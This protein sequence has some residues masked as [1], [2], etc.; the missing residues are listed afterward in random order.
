MVLGVL[1]GFEQW[2]GLQRLVAFLQEANVVVAPDKAHVRGGID[3]GM[4][5]LQHALLHLPGEEL[6]GDLK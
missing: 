2:A 3:E 6:A 4:R 1:H 5:V